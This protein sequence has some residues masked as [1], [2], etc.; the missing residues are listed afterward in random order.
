MLQDNEPVQQIQASP[1]FLSCLLQAND[2][3]HLHILLTKTTF[4]DI[5][6]LARKTSHR[7]SGN[8]R[9]FSNRICLLVKFWQNIYIIDE[10][11]QQHT[12]GVHDMSISAV[13]V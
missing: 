8:N 7:D 4:E 3:K 5:L 1:S 2:L 9:V 11:Q 13:A 6:Y 12:V 10:N